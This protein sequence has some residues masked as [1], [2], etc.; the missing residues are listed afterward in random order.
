MKQDVPSSRRKPIEEYSSYAYIEG[1]STSQIAYALQA[2]SHANI[3]R[4]DNPFLKCTAMF[5]SCNYNTVNEKLYVGFD[6]RN[7]DIFLAKLN[8]LILAVRFEV[9]HSYFN[10]LNII[11]SRIDDNALKKI[12]PSKEDFSK[13]LD[14]GRVPKPTYPQLKLESDQFRGL[15]TMLFSQPSAPVLIPGPFGCGK[16]RL[17]AVA[18]EYVIQNCKDKNIA[19]RVLICCYQ[20]D[21]ANIFMNDYFM[22]MIK[23]K[24]NPWDV[25]VIHVTSQR[26]QAKL[27]EDRYVINTLEFKE[28]FKKYQIKQYLVIVTTCGGALRMSGTVPKDYFTHI[29]IDEGAQ[30]REPETIAPLIMANKDTRIIIAGDSQ[31]VSGER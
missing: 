22:K 7:A 17:L 11:V 8:G 9:K 12:L 31:Q 2:S 27:R 16:T 18:T 30:T 19:G 26:H 4:P 15:Q 1:M 21:S 25:E 20:Q 24:Q 23:D 13:D 5:L 3:I 6:D 29:L 14:L 10:D 28:H